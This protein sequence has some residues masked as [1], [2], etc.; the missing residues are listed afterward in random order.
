MKI[1]YDQG[2]GKI[3]GFYEDDSAIIAP[4]GAG[5]LIIASKR[6]DDFVSEVSSSNP[7]RRERLYL[8]LNLASLD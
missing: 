6:C 4:P 3:Y 5:E 1:L 8:R 7:N 2:T